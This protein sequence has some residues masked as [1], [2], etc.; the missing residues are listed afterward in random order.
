[1]FSFHPTIADLLPLSL[2]LISCVKSQFL[3]F[4]GYLWPA[5]LSI[6][7]IVNHYFVVAWLL[8]WKMKDLIAASIQKDIEKEELLD[9]QIEAGD[10]AAMKASEGIKRN[11]FIRAMRSPLVYWTL[12]PLILACVFLLTCLMVPIVDLFMIAFDL[13]KGFSPSVE[14]DENPLN[15]VLVNFLLQYRTLRVPLEVLLQSVPQTILTGFLYRYISQHPP[16]IDTYGEADN[17]NLTAVVEAVVASAANLLSNG[18]TV[19]LAS[20]MAGR[21][22]FEYLKM[23]MTFEGAADLPPDWEVKIDQSH[24]VIQG[25]FHSMKLTQQMKILNTTLRR[26]HL[27]LRT[28]TKPQGLTEELWLG[29]DEVD[30]LA[31]DKRLAEREGSSAED[32]EKKEHVKSKRFSS[33]SIMLEQRKMVEWLYEWNPRVDERRLPSKVV[34]SHIGKSIDIN[35][36]FFQLHKIPLKSDND[37]GDD[38]GFKEEQLN[39]N[40]K[41]ASTESVTMWLISHR[42]IVNFLV[43]VR[44]NDCNIDASLML[45]LLT[46]GGDHHNSPLTDLLGSTSMKVLDLSNNPLFKCLNDQ[47]RLDEWQEVE[48]SSVSSNDPLLVVERIQSR[49]QSQTHSH[50]PP[51]DKEAAK[52]EERLKLKERERLRIKAIRGFALAL[53]HNTSLSEINFSSTCMDP[54]SAIQILEALSEPTEQGFKRKL[55][56]SHNPLLKAKEEYVISNKALEVQAMECAS[57]NPTSPTSAPPTA[58]GT[59][60]RISWGAGEGGGGLGDRGS[61]ASPSP[62]VHSLID[63]IKQAAIEHERASKELK[64]FK[65]SKD[66]VDFRAGVSAQQKL[67]LLDRSK[68]APASLAFVRG[69]EPNSLK[70]E[71]G[72]PRTSG[73]EAYKSLSVRVPAMTDPFLPIAKISKQVSKSLRES[74]FSSASSPNGN[75]IAPNSPNANISLVGSSSN[76]EESLAQK[77]LEL[78]LQA[79]EGKLK[80]AAKKL[81]DN[82]EL[83]PALHEFYVR[84]LEMALKNCKGILD[85]SLSTTFLQKDELGPLMQGVSLNETLTRLDLS[86]CPMV[87]EELSSHKN[88][89][90]TMLMENKTI[91]RLVLRSTGRRDNLWP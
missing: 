83:R 53:R 41:V 73:L 56:M 52:K 89:F 74:D 3:L 69:S 59:N 70:N 68:E 10:V 2:S 40:A 66:M 45:P 48:R 81:K 87:N 18:I 12:M 67:G 1:M 31:A 50:H 76:G 15:S 78:Q 58:R 28:A 9:Q 33:A 35:V 14:G 79:A 5:I 77:K 85:L 32:E 80:D 43:S 46:K 51:I 30:R 86:N 84:C 13:I 88:S 90:A 65:A 8:A 19:Y 64:S 44:L 34:E 38:M 4:N 22:F 23:A 6:I 54:Y 29:W 62:F 55:D 82:P 47:P 72:S 75:D 36:R 49:T 61:R 37:R 7:F 11:S 91:T 17:F 24:I 42:R 26:N 27:T 60:T 20:K 39:A 71:N 63:P 21:S 25:N 57:L 16:S